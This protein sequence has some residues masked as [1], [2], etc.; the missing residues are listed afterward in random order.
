[1][2]F[3]SIYD[4]HFSQDMYHIGVYLLCVMFT[5]LNNYY[6]TCDTDKLTS[7]TSNFISKGWLPVTPETYK[8]HRDAA[9]QVLY[10][11][12]ITSHT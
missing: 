8:Y 9:A 10:R 3:T 6:G 2:L 11:G 5:I 7:S 12:W 1:M 4:S